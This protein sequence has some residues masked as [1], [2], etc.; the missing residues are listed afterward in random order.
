MQVVFGLSSL[1]LFV[2]VMYHRTDV[3]ESKAAAG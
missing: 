3:G 2:P 1:L